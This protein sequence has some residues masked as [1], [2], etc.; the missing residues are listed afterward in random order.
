MGFGDGFEGRIVLG[1]MSGYTTPCY[2]RFMEPFGAA[3]SVTEM[4]SA[5]GLFHDPKGSARFAEA[6]GIAPTGAQVFGGDPAGVARGASMALE[7]EPRLRFIDVNMG[8]PMKKVT[9]VGAGSALLDDPELCGRIVRAVKDAVDIPVTAKIRL[10]RERSTMTWRKVLDELLRANVD[11]VCIHTRTADQRY[12]GTADHGE[13]A[14]LQERIPIPLIVSGD[15]FTAADAARAVETTGAKYVMVARGGVGNPFLL[16]Q[17][18]RLLET[19]EEL[20]NPS[21]AQQA[22]WCLGLMDSIIAESGPVVALG[23]MRGLGPKF[24]AGCRYSREYRRA[25]TDPAT[26]LDRMRSMLE[27][28]R[29]EMGDIAFR[30]A[31]GC[32][33]GAFRARI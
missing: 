3:A 31:E 12:A 17:I 1:P 30:S 2:R 5:S 24:L 6:S 10:G 20:P 25:F 16:T 23:R 29:D 14:G 33:A 13:I 4:V 22:E 9:R 18:D 21:L 7:T 11:A 8:C 19:G 15:V 27:R 32:R 26:D 28:V